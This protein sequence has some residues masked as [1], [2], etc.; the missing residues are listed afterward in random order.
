[1]FWINNSRTAW[2]TLILMLFWVPWTIHYKMHILFFKKLQAWS[3]EKY[4]WAINSSPKPFEASCWW[5]INHSRMSAEVS[6]FILQYNLITITT[7]S[8]SVFSISNTSS[9]FHG[10]NVLSWT[11]L[12]M[13]FVEHNLV[14]WSK[15]NTFKSCAQWIMKEAKLCTVGF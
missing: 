12:G 6:Y 4:W 14:L 11:D 7:P 15:Y 3:F 5:V 10:R 2:H 9:T 1:M 8:I 13:I